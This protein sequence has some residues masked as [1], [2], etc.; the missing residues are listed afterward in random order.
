MVPAGFRL[1]RI[2]SWRGAESGAGVT[3]MLG[4]N[5]Q[6]CWGRCKEPKQLFLGLQR[7]SSIVCARSESRA[8]RRIWC[9]RSESISLALSERYLLRQHHILG[10][11]A[12][13]AYIGSVVAFEWRQTRH[14]ACARLAVSRAPCYLGK[15]SMHCNVVLTFQPRVFRLRLP[16]GFGG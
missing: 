15:R 6:S 14:E 12:S 3:T 11:W 1:P 2:P 10:F 13:S 4:R 16:R 5:A 7:Y 9:I 8:F